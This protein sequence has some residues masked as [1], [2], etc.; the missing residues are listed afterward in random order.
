MS[1]HDLPDGWEG[2]TEGSEIVFYSP[3]D[4][5]TEEDA[6][7][8]L[9]RLLYGPQPLDATGALATLLAVTG[10]VSVED[11]ANAVGLT[12]DDLVHEAQAWAAFSSPLD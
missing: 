2:T 5:F 4:E 11:A 6:R 8:L 9:E 10:I 3:D 7:A 1:F 12:V